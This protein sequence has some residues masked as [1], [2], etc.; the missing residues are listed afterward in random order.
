MDAGERPGHITFHYRSITILW[1]QVVGTTLPPGLFGDLSG[2]RPGPGRKKSSFHVDVYV[3][4]N[5]IACKQKY[6]TGGD[7]SES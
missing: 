3:N 1:L 5:I 2:G 7:E 6:K 4:V